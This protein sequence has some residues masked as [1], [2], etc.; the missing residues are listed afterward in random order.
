MERNYP[1]WIKGVKPEDIEQ[2][3]AA[4]ASR[5]L[6]DNVDEDRRIGRHSNNPW[7]DQRLRIAGTARAYDNRSLQRTATVGD[8]EN[9]HVAPQ[10]VG[11]WC[12]G[13]TLLRLVA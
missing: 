9:L 3:K 8:R 5:P 7:E 12:S 13:F 2:L 10:T 6:M 1:A 4:M 11:K